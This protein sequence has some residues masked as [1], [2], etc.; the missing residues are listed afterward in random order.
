ML[1]SIYL[2][3]QKTDTPKASV[4]TAYIFIICIFAYIFTALYVYPLCRPLLLIVASAAHICFCYLC[5]IT[6]MALSATNR[7]VKAT[8]KH[9]GR[10]TSFLMLI[11]LPRK[12]S[13]AIGST[14]SR[15]LP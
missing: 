15:Y 11:D 2:Q 5:S 9:S 7:F 12:A 10:K 3:A 6:A 8:A 4:F 14:G 1:Q 13:S